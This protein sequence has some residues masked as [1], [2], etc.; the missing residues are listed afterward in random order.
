LNPVRITATNYRSFDELDLTLPDGC[1]AIVGAN[2]AGKSSIMN[3]IEL[4]LFGS[5]SLGDYLTDDS[6]ATEMHVGLEFEHAGELYR[7]RRSYSA[8]GRGQAKVDF[9]RFDIHDGGALD[10]RDWQPLTRETAGATQELICQT[11]GLS[12]ETFRASAFLGQGDGAVFTEAQPRER[13][14]ILA[15]VLGLDVWDR[16]LERARADRRAAESSLERVRG[17]IEVAEHELAERPTIVAERDAHGL[18]QEEANPPLPLPQGAVADVGQ[19]LVQA[20]ERAAARSAAT[21]LLK[22]RTTALGTVHA[23]LR[24]LAG[25]DAAIGR[26]LLEKPALEARADGLSDL[27]A[28][29]ATAL[30]AAER[31]R[32]RTRM[33]LER[34]RLFDEAS[35]L[36][37]RATKLRLDAKVLEEHDAQEEPASCDRCGQVLGGDARARVAKSYRDEADQLDVRASDFD[38]KAKAIE[39]PNASELETR[40]PETIRDEVARANDAKARLA[41]FA[42]KERRLG[43]IA[44]EG[45]HLQAKIP[46]LEREQAEARAEVEKLTDGD[47]LERLERETAAATH[48]LRAAE[49]RVQSLAEAIARCDARLERVAKVEA[50]LAASR[51]AIAAAQKEIDLLA[52]AERAYGR[53]G[54]PALIVE[55][56]AIPQIELEASR[57]LAELGTSFRV[58]LRTQRALK[59]SEGLRDTLDIVILTGGVERVYESFSGGERTRINLAL[60]IAL[61]RLLAHRRGAESRLLAIDEPEGL[62]AEGFERLAA[63]LDRLEAEFDTVLV[64]SHHPDLRTAFDQ[65]ITVTKD[66]DGVSRI[67]VGA[68]VPA[69]V[70]A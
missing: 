36:I 56:A 40:P 29:L 24:E 52:L 58:E 69:E 67:E 37:E 48:R 2:G 6:D 14:A 18:A 55:N 59:S 17:S 25:V 47:E 16:L 32:E 26:E 66:D 1:C 42:E 15:E 60:R 46:D 38:E 43:E 49:T 10:P 44:A 41:A 3:V 57:I 4:A 8:R 30:E 62:D 39:I 51:E 70:A 64:I 63:V 31:E 7:V 35:A 22:A 13:K 53:D 68:G 19:R 28:E 21:E 61:A 50:D 27:E 33:V 11:I 12:R 45:D 23:R 65:V 9:E 20:R 5:R 54:I 34:N